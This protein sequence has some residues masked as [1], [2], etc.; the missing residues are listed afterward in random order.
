[1]V[2]PV[3]KVGSLIGKKGELIKKLCE[4]TRAKVR[5]LDGV[6]GTTDRIVLIF[7]KEEPEE[8]LSPAMNAVIRVFKRVNDVSDAGGDGTAQAS[9]NPTACSVRL[10]VPSQQAISLIG[11]QGSSIKSIQENSGATIRI[12]TGDKLPHYATEE[13]RVVDIQGETLKVLKALEAVLEHLRKFL[14][15]H[16]IVPLFEKSPNAPLAQ[17][18]AQAQ[19]QGQPQ[20]QDSQPQ[21]QAGIQNPWSNKAQSLIHAAQQSGIGSEYT[22]PLT[23]DSL[24]LERDSH[25]DSQM[26]R[27]GGLSSLYRPEP[28]LSG[29]HPPGPLRSAA[30]LV[31]QVTQT[32]QIPLTYAEDIIGI[33][34]GNIAYIRRTSGAVLTV[35]ESGGLADEITVEIKGTSNQ[36]QTAQQLIQDFISGHKEAPVSSYGGLDTGLRSSSYSRIGSS[37]Y[38]AYP[39][40][41]LPSQ[42]GGYDSGLGGYRD[43]RF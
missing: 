36:V 2:V 3:V 1:M 35:Q 41:S 31:T 9:S 5:I 14:V 29:L 42:Y 27:P 28:P 30:A 40:S 34:G 25:F 11:K 26:E 23:R 20:S 21:S 4:E 15:D 17:A 13:E 6:S 18:Q 39:S 22:L 7:G 32:M 10:L 8:E 37:A 24:F 33:G 19:A 12:I 38:S 16:S 43:Y